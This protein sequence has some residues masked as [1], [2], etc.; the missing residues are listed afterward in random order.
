LADADVVLTCTGADG[1][2]IDAD[3][4]T[5]VREPGR[6]VVFVDIAVPRDVDARVATLPDT[7]VLDL[8]DLSAWADRG[9]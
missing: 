6:P 3:M 4:V 5:A 8:D 7:V 2:L 1:T 9:R